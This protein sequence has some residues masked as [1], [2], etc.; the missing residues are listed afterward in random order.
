MGT[1][2]KKKKNFKPLPS[3][4]IIASTDTLGPYVSIYW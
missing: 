4:A 3:N 1:K 2:F